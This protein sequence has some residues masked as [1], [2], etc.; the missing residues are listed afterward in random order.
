MKSEIET[1]HSLQ[2]II[3]AMKW[4]KKKTNSFLSA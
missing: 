4:T 2:V 1:E 3:V